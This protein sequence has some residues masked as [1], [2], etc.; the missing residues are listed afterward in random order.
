MTYVGA[1]GA[2]DRSG[3]VFK[4]GPMSFGFATYVNESNLRNFIKPVNAIDFKESYLGE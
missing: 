3:T 4:Y 2:Y 1:V